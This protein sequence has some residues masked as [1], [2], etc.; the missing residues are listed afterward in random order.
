KMN[1]N[2]IIGEPT[3]G[4]VFKSQEEAY[5]YYSNYGIQKGF[6]VMKR[7]SKRGDDGV[8]RYFTFACVKNDQKKKSMGKNSFASKLSTKTVKTENSVY[9]Y[10]V[11]EDVK[12][13][14]IR[15]VAVIAADDEEKF[16]LVMK[17]IREL[18]LKI[19]N[20]EKKIVQTSSSQ[21]QDLAEQQQVVSRT[22][23]VLSPMVTRG[24]GRPATKRK[25]SRLE[26]V[27]QKLKKKN[28][29]KKL[30]E[31]E[32]NRLKS[33]KAST[34]TLEAN[35]M[36]IKFQLM[37]NITCQGHQIHAFTPEIVQFNHKKSFWRVLHAK[38]ACFTHLSRE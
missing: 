29:N 30:K 33:T 19:T 16:E 34:K 7:S 35:S 2:E 32:P 3:L 9:E 21:P 26:V 38:A 4:M 5:S 37:E 36:L 1:E 25:I 15:K 6:G 13:G 10:R 14:D 11:E 17:G 27:V 24:K 20:D 22:N 31:S 23:K 18:K 28:Q 12:V 8:V